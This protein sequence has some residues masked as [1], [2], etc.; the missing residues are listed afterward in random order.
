L[1]FE[2]ALLFES[3][4]NESRLNVPPPGVTVPPLRQIP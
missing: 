3:R 4:L 2:N 1:P